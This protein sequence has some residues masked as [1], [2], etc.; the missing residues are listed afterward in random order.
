MLSAKIRA[1]IAA[2]AAIVLATLS[3][4]LSA[5]GAVARSTVVINEPSNTPAKISLIGPF[6]W[7]YNDYSNNDLYYLTHSGFNYVDDKGSVVRN[8]KF[9]TYSVVKSDVEDFQVKYTI[10]KG[11]LWSDGTPIDAVDLLL[12]HVIRSSK[13]SKD[14]GLGNPA[15]TDPAFGSD[16]YST[17]YDFHVVGVPVISSDKLSL[18]VTFDTYFTGWELLSPF[19]F[20]AHA[21]ERLVDNRTTLGTAAENLV[22]KTKFLTDFTT[23]ATARLTTMGSIWKNSYNLDS[24]T[25][26]TNPLLLVCNGAYI[27]SVGTAATSVTLI[28]N[29]KYT[30]GPALA[31]TNGVST[32][33]LKKFNSDSDAITALQESAVDVYTSY[34]SFGSLTEANQLKAIST[35]TTGAFLSST[36]EHIDLRFGARLNSGDTYT[37]PFLSSSLQGK[38]IRHAFLLAL[39]REQINDTQVKPVLP[40]ATPLNSSFYTQNEIGYAA[41]IA[42]NGISEFTSGT[43]AQRTARAL[44][45]V[46]NY[47]PDAAADNQVIDIHIL[48]SSR[49]SRVDAIDLIKAEVAKAGFNLIY[50]PATNW[51]S[52]LD[53]V[54]FDVSF[55]AWVKPTAQN[56]V[57][58]NFLTYG[59]NNHSG[60]S[61]GALDRLLYGMDFATASSQLSQ[62]QLAAEKEL[63]K[64]YWTMPLYQWPINY[65][66]NKTLVGV[67]PSGFAPRIVWNFWEWHY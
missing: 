50:E 4:Q 33:I 29:A 16:S 55:F 1:A 36:Y 23:R 66:F 10:T 12:S 8:T 41:Q 27:P 48:S 51:A 17:A 13:Y 59:A 62:F 15:S 63:I 64:N 47:Y 37:G 7:Q 58:S 65:S 56:V 2:I 45:L 42:S 61:S 54:S 18:T 14:A 39:P 34:N 53:D 21:L 25:S 19:P 49:Q 35:A 38:D 31:K 30:S 43:Q 32:V 6:S 40:S 26:S 46:R 60:W 24:I 44:E 57:S 5:I 11:Q 9:G 3:L 28:K 52:R 20:P 22:S 67:K